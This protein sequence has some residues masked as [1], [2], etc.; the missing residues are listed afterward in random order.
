[1]E[2]AFWQVQ[3]FFF[4]I[5]VPWSRFGYSWWRFRI[6]R[7]IPENST[8]CA[9]DVKPTDVYSA[10]GVHEFRIEEA[11]SFS[12]EGGG[13]GILI[14]RLV[15]KMCIYTYTY[16]TYVKHLGPIRCEKVP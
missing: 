5:S 16:Y 6:L 10:S 8:P 7:I 11:D 12:N 15:H 2:A 1:M 4:V 14:H 3:W 9:A 13:G